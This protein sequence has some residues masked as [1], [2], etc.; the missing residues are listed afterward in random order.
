MQNTQKAATADGAVWL[1]VI[2]SAQGFQG[3]VTG[4]EADALT[5]RRDAYPT[6]VLLDPSGDVGLLYRARVTPHMFIIDKDSLRFEYI[7]YDI[8][9]REECGVFGCR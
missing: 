8:D 9:S 4:A 2:S 6:A 1:T 7:G 5:R 3:Y